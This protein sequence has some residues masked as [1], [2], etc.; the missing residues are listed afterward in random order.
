M[1]LRSKQTE[2]RPKKAQNASRKWLAVH[3]IYKSTTAVSIIQ[4]KEIR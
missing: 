2:I 3:V 4:R 1:G